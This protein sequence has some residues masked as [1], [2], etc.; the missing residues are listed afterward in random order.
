[1]GKGAPGEGGRPHVCL[2]ADPRE[3]PS[4]KQ[5]T[6]YTPAE[7]EQMLVELHTQWVARRAEM[8]R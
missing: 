1:M 6:G 8:F 2:T 7:M 5:R 3:V 4:F